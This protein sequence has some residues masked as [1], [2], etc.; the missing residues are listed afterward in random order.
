M[1]RTKLGWALAGAI[2]LIAVISAIIIWK[3]VAP[4]TSQQT[5]QD[6]VQ[7]TASH[8]PQRPEIVRPPHT[9]AGEKAVA[10]QTHAEATATPEA[11]ADVVIAGA[12]PKKLLVLSPERRKQLNTGLSAPETATA[13]DGERVVAKVTVENEEYRVTPNQV[14]NFQRIHVSANQLVTVDVNYVRGHDGE[15][16]SIAV[17]DGGKLDNGK[18]TKRE[19]LGP[20]KKFTFQY[21]AT[22][23]RG[24]HRVMLTKG[25][26][27]K[28]LD[29]WVGEP[30][31]SRES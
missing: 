21:Q 18:P 23:Q 7:P 29:F 24:I 3:P 20:D 26:D 19:V 8:A 4:D 16:V 31:P 25:A 22:G 10:S 17:L 11:T 15:T 13:S 28:T 6:T 12:E 14:G 27:Q 1:Q 5:E 9:V 2:I 30:P